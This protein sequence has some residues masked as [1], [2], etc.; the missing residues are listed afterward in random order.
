MA[1]DCS[2]IIVSYNVADL[3]AACLDSIL[4]SDIT[5]DGS[6]TALPHI[7]II[8]VDSAS[9]DHAVS[10]VQENYPQVTL[11]A[12][13]ENVGFT[14]GNNIGLE[15]AQGRYLFLLNP[16]TEL[17]RQALSEMIA[18]LEAHPSVGIVGPHTLNSDGSTQSSRRRFMSKRLAFFESTWLQPYAPQRWLDDYYI[19]DAADDAVLDVD[20]VQGSAL[21]ARRAVYEQIGGLDTGFVMYFEEQDWCKRTKEA[22][23]RVTYLGTAQVTHHGGKSSDQIGPRKHIYFQASKLRYSRKH[24]GRAFAATLMAFLWLNYAWQLLLEGAK[25]LAG[26][27]RALRRERVQTYW[28]VLRSGFRA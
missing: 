20:W 12:Q 5:L 22:G 9:S 6:D 27:K 11:L 3:L 2:I 21:L 1:I 16:D 10:M 13:S 23:W 8:V 26:H 19:A 24:H 15:S 14:A 17:I 4:A 28:Q 18:Y 7:E 25:G